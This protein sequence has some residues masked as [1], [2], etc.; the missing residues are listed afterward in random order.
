M[1]SSV[2][3]KMKNEKFKE[4]CILKNLLDGEQYKKYPLHLVLGSYFGL[5]VWK[6]SIRLFINFILLNVKNFKFPNSEKEIYTFS[7]KRDA[8]S[9]LIYGYFPGAKPQYVRVSNSKKELILGCLSSVF[10]LIK[11]FFFT[12]KIKCSIKERLK[13][14]IGVSIAFKIIDE[15]EK[16]TIQCEKYVAFNS[17]YLME[18]FI[19]YY[20]RNRNIKTCSLQHGMYFQYKGDTPFDVINYENVCAD[21][22]LLWGEYSNQQ[23]S[24]FLPASSTCSVYGYPIEKISKRNKS[25]SILVLLPRDIYLNESM[26]L[27]EYLSNFNE[28]YIVR[29][30]P[31]ILK[32]IEGINLHKKNIFLDINKT[33]KE[34]LCSHQYKVVIGFNSTSIFEAIL[35]EQKVLLF[36]TNSQEFD[37]SGFSEISVNSD[38][39]ECIE[40]V[41]NSI[42][43]RYYFEDLGKLNEL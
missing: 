13:L 3:I 27:L 43:S 19:S 28:N 23:V 34:T 9:D 35:Y 36:K 22:L 17:S 1:K 18:S 40:N 31:S 21:E 24:K 2:R 11:A 5:M 16:Q 8:Y 10:T 6:P 7:T 41:N 15:L 14:I 29:A 20:F 42:N 37:S 12:I 32:N 26:Q 4:Y 33:I 39:D 25:D 30:H 38:L